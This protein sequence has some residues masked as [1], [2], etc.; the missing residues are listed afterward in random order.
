MPIVP[1]AAARLGAGSLIGRATRPL[2]MSGND[3]RSPDAEVLSTAQVQR[4]RHGLKTDDS[5]ACCRRGATS[6]AGAAVGQL[7]WGRWR[8]GSMRA[9][10]P[11]ASKPCRP[12]ATKPRPAPAAA[13]SV[14]TA[15]DHSAAGDLVRSRERNS[16]GEAL[17]IGPVM[18]IL[19]GAAAPTDNVQKLCSLHALNRDFCR[20]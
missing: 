8:G 2:A 16:S 10:Q 9:A 14:A 7:G 1:A 11:A 15:S 18:T 3:S 4:Y 17:S 12:P 19:I 5:D 20:Q 6:R 13:R